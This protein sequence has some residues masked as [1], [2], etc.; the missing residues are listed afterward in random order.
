[1]HAGVDAVDAAAAA[2]VAALAAV[3]LAVDALTVVHVPGAVRVEG[4]AAVATGNVVF[5]KQVA[6]EKQLSNSTR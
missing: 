5:L 3:A 6:V 4:V 2:L 1:M